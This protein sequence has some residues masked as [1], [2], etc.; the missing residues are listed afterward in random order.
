MTGPGV[1]PRFVA[2]ARAES[3]AVPGARKR[4][5]QPID[6]PLVWR[7]GESRA[8]WRT[9]PTGFEVLDRHLPGGGWPATG[10]TEI[11]TGDYGIGEL[12][13]L[14]PALAR[15]GRDGGT[16][17]IV[18]VAPPFIP[19]APAL[20]SHGIGLD[21]VLIVRGCA[22]A[23]GNRDVLWATEQALRFGSCGAVL[24]WMRSVGQAP[25]RRLQLAAEAGRC[26][27]VLFRPP[28]ASRQRSP[29]V[30]RM[31]LTAIGE[32]TRIEILKCRGG[33]PGM[34][35]VHLG[36]WRPGDAEPDRRISP[37]QVDGAL[38]CHGPAAQSP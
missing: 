37:H 1:S 34:V 30:L 29:A 23:R 2:P 24:A 19:H 15:M 33:R 31:R 9:R 25:L 20:H 3:T 26:W 21:R 8:S 16:G 28:D 35:T 36:D 18:W 7:A 6:H 22:D 11:L 13:L 32:Q 12:S 5:E 38:A 17:C 4:V 10:L 14:M 27:T